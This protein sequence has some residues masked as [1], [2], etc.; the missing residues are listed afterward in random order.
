MPD[1]KQFAKEI[2]KPM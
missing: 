2:H 1:M